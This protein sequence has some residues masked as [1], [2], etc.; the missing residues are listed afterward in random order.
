M[1]SWIIPLPYIAFILISML[2]ASIL[3]LLY[4]LPGIILFVLS[5]IL[6]LALIAIA[7]MYTLRKLSRFASLTRVSGGYLILPERAFV[8]RGVVDFVFR[9]AASG[10]NSSLHVDSKIIDGEVVETDRLRI[11]DIC[12]EPFYINISKPSY[13]RIVAPGF[14]VKSDSFSNVITFCLDNDNIPNRKVELEV[15]SGNDRALGVVELSKNGFKGWVW[16][17]TT[18]TGGVS[19]RR[20]ARIEVCCSDQYSTNCFTLTKATEPNVTS[21]GNYNWSLS[22]KFINLHRGYL[23]SGA[24][25][26]IVEKAV[27]A[28]TD[29][30]YI[31]AGYMPG[32]VKV[33]LILNPLR[34][35]EV[36]VT[37]EM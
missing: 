34:G 15:R 18:D 14:I 1:W 26:R 35:H 10:E 28:K 29:R 13:I 11:E 19:R 32:V 21:Y 2:N 37:K 6:V 9:E 8:E 3:D 27:K 4:F 17:S 36:Y 23:T 31:L 7:K 12:R 33:K 30:G 5:F 16:W 25:H 22:D 24:I 20:G